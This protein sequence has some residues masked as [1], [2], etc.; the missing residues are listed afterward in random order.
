MLKSLKTPA[1]MKNP[2]VLIDLTPLYFWICLYMVII[3]HGLWGLSLISPPWYTNN[4]S[5]NLEANL[6]NG[7]GHF[8]EDFVLYIEAR[9]FN[10]QAFFL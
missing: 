8:F 7:R 5:A 1:Q 4:R 2:P 9:Y 3:I 6:R 10:N